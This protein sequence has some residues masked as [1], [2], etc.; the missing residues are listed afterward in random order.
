[1]VQVEACFAS[2]GDSVNLDARQLH[3]LRWMYNGHENHFAHTRWY[4]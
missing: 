1:M 4:S 2:F 3:G